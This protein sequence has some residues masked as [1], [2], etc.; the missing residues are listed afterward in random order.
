MARFTAIAYALLC[1]ASLWMAW[2]VTD[3]N[4]K[5][6]GYGLAVIYGLAS[7]VMPIWMRRVDR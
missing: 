6:T 7:V 5:A 2:A 1:A 4:G 3:P